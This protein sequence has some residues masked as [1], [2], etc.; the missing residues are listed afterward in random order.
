MGGERTGPL[1]L[2]S[3]QGNG[4]CGKRSIL[5]DLIFASFHQGKEE[6]LSAEIE[7]RQALCVKGLTKR[8]SIHRMADASFLSMP[9]SGI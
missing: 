6:S 3:L 1:V 9:I 2:L 8:Q 4:L 5:S 7:R